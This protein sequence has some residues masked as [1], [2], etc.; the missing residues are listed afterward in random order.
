MYNVDHS[1]NLKSAP[2]I[3]GIISIWRVRRQPSLL[4]SE[5][6]LML[7]INAPTM[8]M[9]TTSPSRKGSPS[10]PSSC[11]IASIGPFIT[12]QNSIKSKMFLDNK[13]MHK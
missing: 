6:E 7:P 9:L 3:N 5:T 13:M 12:L 10:K 2:T 11:A 8:N 1:K 4:M